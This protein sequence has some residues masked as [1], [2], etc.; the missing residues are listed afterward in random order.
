MFLRE[1]LFIFFPE[2]ALTACPSFVCLLSVLDRTNTFT[3]KDVF[4]NNEH[5]MNTVSNCSSNH[6]HFQGKLQP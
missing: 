3:G 6:Q 4:S 2:I 5:E 1:E